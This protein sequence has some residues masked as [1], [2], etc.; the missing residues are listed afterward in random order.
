M[1]TYV[2]DTDKGVLAARRDFT[3]Q[4]GEFTE[5]PAKA[6]G[7]RHDTQTRNIQVYNASNK[8]YVDFAPAYQAVYQTDDEGDVGIWL[9]NSSDSEE[10]IKHKQDL[11]TFDPI[12]DEELHVQLPPSCRP[13]VKL[14]TVTKDPEPISITPP[15]QII[16]YMTLGKD[17]MEDQRRILNQSIIDNH[18]AFNQHPNDVGMYTG[19]PYELRLIDGFN[20]AVFKR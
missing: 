3:L 20:G 2:K 15:E 9:L 4:P 1:K 6:Y 10:T 13:D 14:D 8:Q 16:D 17:M 12:D 11:A 5:V 7:N 19:E 18:K